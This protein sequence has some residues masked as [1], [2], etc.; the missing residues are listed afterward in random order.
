MAAGYFLAQHKTQLG[1]NKYVYQ[2]TVWKD[3][4]G[5]L[6]MIFWVKTAPPPSGNIDGDKTS[7]SLSGGVDTINE[8]VKRSADG[9]N[10]IRRHVV[11]A[12]L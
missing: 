2:A 8:V 7:M 1:G 10:V 9:K 5:D 3:R 4:D 12:R 11:C 6:Q